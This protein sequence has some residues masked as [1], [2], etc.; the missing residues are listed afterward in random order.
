[1]PDR[2]RV[3]YNHG[4]ALQ[5][6]GRRDAAEASLRR[7][8]ERAPRDPEIAYALATFYAQGGEWKPARAAADRL[9]ELTEGSAQ[10]RQLLER[11]EHESAAG[12]SSGMLKRKEKDGERW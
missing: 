8:A 7:A 1:M 10:A 6:I 5:R 9:V 3:H 12:S 2:A 4:L 11:I